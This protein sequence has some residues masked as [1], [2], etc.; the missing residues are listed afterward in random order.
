MGD[1]S[2]MFA[3][4]VACHQIMEAYRIPVLIVILNNAEWGAV[5]QSVTMLYPDG[6]AARANQMPLTG[7]SPSPDFCKIAE[8][9]NAFARK[10]TERDQLAGAIADAI[11]AIIREKRPALLDVRVA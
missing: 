11:D 10:V 3:N 4:P 1:G 8:A 2:Y 6:F 7:L 5:R 9:S